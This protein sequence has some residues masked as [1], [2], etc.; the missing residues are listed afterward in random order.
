MRY[1]LP[2]YFMLIFAAGFCCRNARAETPQKPNII[3][4][5][6]DDLGYSEVGCYGQQII[7]TPAI[8]QIAR[9][10]IKLTQFYAGQ[11]VC[12]PSRCVLMTGKHTG[13]SYIRNNG[14]P[15]HLQYLAP[16]FG[17]EFPGQN[18]IPDEEL[19][20]AEI[21]KQQGYATAAAGKWGLGHFGTSGDPNRQ[22][23]ELFYG[24]LE[25]WINIFFPFELC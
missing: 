18:P 19:T 10:G 12:A 14:D 7:R 1:Q 8:D 6:A 4:I 15:K 5:L 9:Q 24:F 3:F 2:L 25:V 17:W 21:L 23:F 11:A 20:V 13:H 22:G 16:R